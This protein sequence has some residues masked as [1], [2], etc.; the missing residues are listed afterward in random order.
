MLETQFMVRNRFGDFFS[1]E[2]LITTKII[3]AVYI[4][5]A[6]LI[7]ISGVSAM[8]SGGGGVVCISGLIGIIVGNVIWRLV[9]EGGVVLFS[10]HDR[11]SDIHNTFRDSLHTLENIQEAVEEAEE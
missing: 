9:C 3:G 10:I 11:L 8:A 1:F 6:L 5:G 2:K 4:I 7:T